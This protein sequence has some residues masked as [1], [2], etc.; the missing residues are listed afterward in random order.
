M[1]LKFYYDIPSNILFPAVNIG[2]S[3]KGEM[4]NIFLRW[5]M[6]ILVVASHRIPPQQ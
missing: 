2:N 1:T 6:Y 5:K 3:E 4:K